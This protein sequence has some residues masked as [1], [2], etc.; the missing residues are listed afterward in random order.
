MNLHWRVAFERGNQPQ[1]RPP[2]MAKRRTTIYPAVTPTGYRLAEAVERRRDEVAREKAAGTNSRGLFFPSRTGGWLGSGNFH[3]DIFEPAATLAGWES[4]L[5]ERANGFDDEGR[6]QTR[7]QRSWAL[8]WHSLRHTFCTV[9]LEEW[10]LDDTV[11]AQLAGH[12]NSLTTRRLYVGA[13]EDSIAAALDAT[14]G[15]KV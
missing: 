8:T 3:R 7:K 11:V 1:L 5:R 9:A 13:A 12:K 2:K 15:L 6:P 10:R 4:T 14:A